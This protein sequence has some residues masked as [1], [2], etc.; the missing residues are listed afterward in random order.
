M[1]EELRELYKY[2]ELLCMITYRDIK[3]RYKQ[4]I[5]GFMW[6]VLMPILIV[7]SG[8][9][10]RYAYALAAHKPLDG[11]HCQRGREIAALGISGFQYSVFVSTASSTTRIWSPRSIFRKRFFRWRR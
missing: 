11:R 10:V 5:M 4:S 1:R 7:L 3:V 9:V 6:A 8:I 2:R